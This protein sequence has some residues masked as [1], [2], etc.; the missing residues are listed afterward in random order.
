MKRKVSLFLDSG[1]YSWY[2]KFYGQTV[3]TGQKKKE[4]GGYIND[5]EFLEYRDKYVE[6]LKENAEHITVY[7]NL[8][9]IGHAEST[10]KMQKFLESKGLSPLPVFHFGEDMKWLRR[11]MDEGYD[12][13][14][15]GGVVSLSSAKQTA[16]TF[17]DEIFSIIC[18]SKT[19]LPKVRLHGFGLTTVE[20]MFR[21]PWYSV[22][23]T[24]WVM[25]SRFGMVYVPKFKQGKF[26]YTQIPYKVV[27]SNR[28]PA[29]KEL[30]G[31]HFS[32][33]SPNEQEIMNK[34]FHS[35]GYTIG[36]S[37]YKR[38]E[39]LDYKLKEGEKWFGKEEADSQRSIH[40]ARDG[41]VKHGWSKDLIVEMVIEKGLSN[42]YSQ[43]DVMNILY[44][45][46]LEKAFPKWP[47]PYK[48]VNK[49]SKGFG[50]R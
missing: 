12:Y 45:L 9:V 31:K 32:T 28:S 22:D 14:G 4:V 30:G 2:S 15:I 17:Y 7:A 29:V 34:Y 13:I 50:L 16:A 44:F 27:V 42:E 8:D 25:T 38:V 39:S 33:F 11:Y 41:Y 46:D 48:P 24:S 40:G 37:T 10:Y 20:L 19:G 43:R 3:T 6:F 1:A 36:R 35:K 21:F 26:D 18:D 23:S 5:P 49:I 47:W